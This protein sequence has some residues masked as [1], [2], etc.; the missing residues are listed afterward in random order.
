MYSDYFVIPV[1]VQY[2]SADTVIWVINKA[3][4]EC[5]IWGPVAMKFLDQSS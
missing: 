5:H 2:S 3:N 4:R 1:P